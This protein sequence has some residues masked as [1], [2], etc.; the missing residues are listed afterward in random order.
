MTNEQAIDILSE[1]A[2]QAPMTRNNHILVQRAV[3]HLRNAVA[4]KPEQPAV[5]ENA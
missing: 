4:E 5:A 2:A 3:D 1:A